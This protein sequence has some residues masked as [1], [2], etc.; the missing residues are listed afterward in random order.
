MVRLLWLNSIARVM[1][2]SIWAYSNLS[3][4]KS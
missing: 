2:K 1:P 4:R 3:K